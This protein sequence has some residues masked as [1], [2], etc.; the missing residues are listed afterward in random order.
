MFL[1]LALLAAGADPAPLIEAERAFARASVENGIMVAFLE[2]L[3]EKAIVFRPQPVDGR[4]FYAEKGPSDNVL[5]WGPAFAEIAASGDF[6]YTG[7][8]WE[9]RLKPGEEPKTFG[10]Y[11]SVWKKQADGKWRAVA[12]AGVS[13]PQRVPVPA[14][15]ALPPHRGQSR[16]NAISAELLYFDNDYSPEHLADDVRVYREGAP[17]AQGKAVIVNEPRV[18]SKTGGT[19]I[20]ASGDL[21]YTYGIAEAA[22]GKVSSYL[23]IWRR[24]S[25]KWRVVVDLALEIQ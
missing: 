5:S 22:G 18:Q 7:G 20:S 16:E 9:L 13:H 2:H 11:L 15:V 23:R 8:P 3:A 21:G 19:D 24:M 10:H 14:R 25:G 12:D 4:K 17:P 6:G 1:A